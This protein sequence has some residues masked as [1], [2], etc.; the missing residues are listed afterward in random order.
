M[1]VY[2]LSFIISLLSYGAIASPYS[3][4]TEPEKIVSIT[5]ALY[6]MDYYQAQVDLWE[7]EVEKNE[8]NVNARM[9]FYLACR[10]VNML[11]PDQ[12]PHDLG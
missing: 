7:K 12:N 11:T 1:K 5:Q 3:A 2:L 10:V 8:S 9:N 4:D 6:E